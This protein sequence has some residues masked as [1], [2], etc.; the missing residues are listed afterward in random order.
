MCPS[1]GNI[2]TQ[3]NMKIH[4]KTSNLPP[5]APVF[6]RKDLSRLGKLGRINKRAG[7]IFSD[8]V[9]IEFTMLCFVPRWLGHDHWASQQSSLFPALGVPE[10]RVFW[11]GV[12]KYSCSQS[13]IGGGFMW[14]PWRAG[15]SFQKIA[16][17]DEGLPWAAMFTEAALSDFLESGLHLPLVSLVTEGTVKR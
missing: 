11:G 8:C 1:E 13:G 17:K 6:G 12:S 3:K 5:S 7:S 14:P 15:L 2:S 4:C 16:P 10:G 9:L